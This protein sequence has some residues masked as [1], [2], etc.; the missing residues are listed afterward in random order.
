MLR[1][2]LHRA[3][4]AAFVFW[5]KDYRPFRTALVCLEDSGYPSLLHFTITGMPATLEPR[6]PE[7]ADA[8]ACFRELS[9]LLS[10]ERL[11]WRFDPILFRPGHG[12]VETLATFRRLCAMLEGA[13]R[14]C[15]TSFAAPY[16]RTLRNL[17][18]AGIPAGDVPLSVQRDLTA[19]MAE[20]AAEHGISLLA[21]ASTGLV[22]EGIAAASCIDPLLLHR[23]FPGCGAPAQGQ[24]SR[25]GCGCSRSIDIGAYASCGHG[26]LYCY[27]NDSPAAG[28]RGLAGC[29]P[30]S[31]LLGI[32]PDSPPHPDSGP[33]SSVDEGGQP[34]LFSGSEGEDGGQLRE[35]AEG[36]DHDQRDR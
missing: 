6:V 19:R 15:Y 14:R 29:D 5:S 8:I 2:S 27:A 13:T 11:L 32:M 23:L 25:P 18:Q 1:V 10:A 30:A 9:R 35:F 31:P 33:D 34:L 3:D 12:P 21:C 22:R 24:P 36:Q 16:A 26:C 28:L 4:V 7:T 20:T 17:Q